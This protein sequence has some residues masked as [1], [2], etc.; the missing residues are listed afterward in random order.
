MSTLSKQCSRW[1]K[2]AKM[3]W[4]CFP[5]HVLYLLCTTYIV[6]LDIV[7]Y[8]SH[9]VTSEPVNQWTKCKGKHFEATFAWETQQRHP[10]FS[11]GLFLVSITAS[12]GSANLYMHVQFI[13]DLQ[14]G[15]WKWWMG[16]Q[17]FRILGHVESWL[18]QEVTLFLHQ[19]WYILYCHH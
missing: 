8:P 13:P 3:N 15:H 14:S 18:W 17:K 5:K 12:S 6:I 7:A 16:L 19:R 4:E 11:A 2:H 10:L 9:R 1:R